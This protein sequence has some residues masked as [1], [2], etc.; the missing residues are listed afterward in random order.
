MKR[1]FIIYIIAVMIVAFSVAGAFAVSKSDAKVEV[2]DAKKLMEKLISNEDIR[3]F[4]PYLSY[5]ECKSLLDKAIFQLDDS[6]YDLAAYYAAVAA[7]QIEA[8][9]NLSMAKLNRFKKI[10]AERDYFKSLAGKASRQATMKIAMVEANIQKEGAAYKS[11]LFDGTLFT[12]GTYK[13][14]P[15]GQSKLDKIFEVLKLYPASKIIVDGHTKRRDPD[16]RRSDEKARSVYDYFTR[17]KELSPKRVRF[18]GKGDAYPTRINDKDQTAD[19]VEVV[20]TGV[21]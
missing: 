21:K 13:L 15:S 16:N 14:S 9:L 6:E 19:R 11:I 20:L 3:E 17:D 5:M 8:T 12:K 4:I 10:K 1:N 2:D 7:I 18:E